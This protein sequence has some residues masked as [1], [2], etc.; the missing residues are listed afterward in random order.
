MNLNCYF[1]DLFY[2]IRVSSRVVTQVHW[3]Q[4]KTQ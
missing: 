3:E 4:L 2:R 1:I